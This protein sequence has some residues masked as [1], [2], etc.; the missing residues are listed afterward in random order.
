MQAPAIPYGRTARR[1]T[2]EFLPPPLRAA[3]ESHLGGPVAEAVSQ[4][5]GFTPGFASVLSTADGA[6]AFV[7]AANRKAQAPIASAYAEEGRKRTLLGDVVPAPALLWSMDD[8]HEDGWVVLGFETSAG[9][10]PSRPWTDADLGI[11][12]D[13]AEE[14]ADR[15]SALPS[16]TLDALRLDPITDDIPEL[17]TSWS[18]V[19]AIFPERDHLEDADDLART[20][21]DLPDRALVHADMRDDNILIDDSDGVAVACDWNWP[22]LGPAWLDTVDLLTAARGD[23]IDVEPLLA[24]RRLTQDVDPEAIDSW[25]AAYC[26]FMTVAGTRPAPSSSPFLPGHALWSAEAS[27]EWLCARRRWR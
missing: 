23:G 9:R 21:A 4:D 18:K 20:F 10:L 12:L 14:I 1:L 11:A 25:L 22:A 16:E 2:W 15:T 26:G 3:I 27:W 17:V 6:S 24:S 8:P 19:A 7:K 13:L 5:A